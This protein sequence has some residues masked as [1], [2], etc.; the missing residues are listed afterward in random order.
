MVG[1]GGTGS[2]LACLLARLLIHLRACGRP[3]FELILIDGDTVELRNI[4]RQAFGPRDVGANK[5]QILASRLNAAFGLRISAVP[6]MATPA[7][8]RSLAPPYRS[9][10]IVLGAVDTPGARAV[11]AGVLDSVSWRLWIDAGNHASAGQ[12]VVGSTTRAAALTGC[13]ALGGLCTALPAL[14][15]VYHDALTVPAHVAPVGGCD[16]AVAAGEQSLLINTQMATVVAQYV[17]DLAIGRRITT[18]WTEIDLAH[19]SMCA[20]A[21]TAPALASATGIDAAVLTRPPAAKRRRKRT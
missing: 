11:L 19:G 20:H 1:C 9:Y 4:G 8:L 2:A 7:L 14:P 18:F 13:L 12:V 5:A 17:V 21:I 16:L 6:C 15:L 3:P 10:G